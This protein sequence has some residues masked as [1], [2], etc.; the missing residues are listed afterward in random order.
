MGDLETNTGVTG[1]KEEE[2]L[3]DDNFVSEEEGGI[4]KPEESDTSFQNN[5]LT[6]TEELSRDRSE[7]ALSGG[8][9]SLFIHTG[10][11][12]VSSENFMLSRGT[13]VNGP[14]SHSTSTKTSIMN[15][16]SVS[17]TT[18]QPGG[19]LSDSC[20]TLTVVHDLQLPAKSTTQKSNQHQVLFLLPDVAHA[21]NLTHS[22][23]NLPT[24]ASV[25]CDS[26]KTVGNSVDSTLVD[27]V[28][29][30]EDDKN[31][32][33]KDDCVDTLTSISSG[34]G[35]FR[36]GCDPS[37]DPQKEFIQF[38][39]TN[40]ET[41]EKSPIHCK[42]GLEKKRKRKMDV[43][44][45][46][47]YTEDC[48]DDTS[49]IPSKSKLLN[50]EFLEQNEELQIVEPQKYSLSKVKPES[51]DEELETVDGIQQL[52]YSPTS[53]C[54]EDTSPV[55]TSTFLSNTLK[56]K[57]EENDSEPPSTF[58]TDEPSFYPCT[59]CNV[60]FREKKHLHRHMMYHLDGNSHF[61][62]LNVPRPYA[63][64]ECGRT[65]RDRNSLLKHMI[66]HQERRQKLM[67]EIRELKELQDEGRSARLQ[68]PQCVFGTNCPKTF[69]QHAKTHEKDKRYYCCEEC[70][71]MAVTENELECHRGIAHGAVV[72]CSI[73][74]SDLS[75]RK[76]QKKASLKDPY[77]G[78]SRKSSTYMC[79]LCPFATS[80]RSILK[81]HMAYLH[82]AS[83]LDPFGSHLRLDKRK[84]SLIEE[85]LDFRSR[86]K[87]LIKHSSTF[88]KNS[89]LKQ[90]VKRSF[91]STS[92]S[93]NFAK[94]HKRP[95]RIQKA[96][97]SVSQS[98]VSVCNLNSTNKNFFTRNSID[99]KRRC[100]HQAAKQKASAKKSNYLY[101]HK[102]EN[103]RIIKKSSDSYPLHLKKEESK[104]VSALHLFSSSSNNCFV[105]DSNSLDCK[106]AEGCKDHRHV[107]V[108]R[109][110]KE[111][112]REGSVTGDD[113][114]C[115]P[116]FLHKM[117]V[118]VL[119][120]LNSA[121]KKDSYETEDESS[122]DNVELCDYTTQS[123]EDESYSDINQ[124]HVN[125]FPIFKG[126]MEDN[127][128]GDKS[129]L[130]YEQNDGFYFEYYED[131]EGS[132]FL[133]DLHDP[134]NLENVGSALPKHNSVFHWTDL[135][136]EKKS[137]P[138][139]P[140]TFETGVGL[141][142][143]VRG[144]LHRAG[145]SYEARH[146][147]S[148]EQIATS[149]K[150]QH[151]K[152]AGTGTPVKRVRK[153]IEKSE[154]SSEHTCQLCGGWFD[155]KI[156]LSN[157]VRG[158]LKR[159]G[160]TKWDAHKSPICVLNEMMQN[161]EKYEKIL[162]AL[163]SRRIIPR[164]F[165]AQKFASN[166]DFL[167][168]NVI[169]LEAYHN[170]LKTE[171]ISVSASEEEGLS[172]LNECDE[173][174]A[175]LHDEKRNQSLTLIELLKNKRLGEERNPDI[176][177]QKIH[178]QTARKRFVQ[179]CVLPLNEDSPLMYQPQK[180]D[181]TMQSALDCK[182]KKSR[183]RSGSKKKMLPL[184]HSADEVYILRCRFCGLVFRG[185][186]S[187]QEDW[188][189]HLQRHIVNANLPRTGAGMVEVTS[190]LKKPAS[191]TE[192]SF[193]LLMAE[194]AS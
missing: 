123:V 121:E 156:G 60:N 34:T 113:L 170:G 174:K 131:A 138:Y 164:P 185:P 12:T 81:K 112:R 167:S 129:S 37:W 168:Q 35:G 84:G 151:F 97:K 169:P 154:T 133:H 144:H 50:V 119:Q 10:A 183:S 57:C 152:R 162:K 87:Q 7:K 157:H 61:R 17:L 153:A 128:A 20:S 33:V 132:N 25:G 24:S 67:E 171:D 31:L 11:P 190:L 41:I 134:Q 192:T 184:P 47:R 103:Y 139:C 177:P 6:L 98:S 89:A 102:Y 101:R 65:F 147:V 137:C 186:L 64:R 191:I 4:P 53:N 56:N 146:V 26:Q 116:D 110:V 19:H 172:F 165:V 15:K 16:G 94:L 28:E 155:T 40:E 189:K 72:K 175:V 88:P 194:A 158:H 187:V 27:Q 179:K 5:T 73:I 36:S 180:M 96:R 109:V 99:Q 80:A 159:L 125:L 79:K 163:N 193:S 69:V 95:Y 117:T 143:H 100:F 63:C 51:T 52:I 30:C 54:A 2:I 181:L 62:H 58:S 173:T 77:L 141:S 148:P 70:N 111:S 161:E 43:S 120:K 124:E 108:K 32:L 188:I 8:Q 106:R 59:K 182:Q 145:L 22:I 49:C 55:H 42:V 118:V 1:A 75:Q 3:C 130:G 76:S 83:C 92:Q 14:V 68:C 122:W 85:S 107:A 18:G 178:N 135:S 71:F 48:F 150:M 45:I 29:V 176:S 9:A 66:I 86:T 105:M 136:L 149:D 127:E 93:S 166:D 115:Y 114:D 38:L 126:K 78:S 160:K 39:M 82:S 13:A 74:G 104:S 90:D 46:T 142:N 21:K 91:G 23:K 140:A 44:K